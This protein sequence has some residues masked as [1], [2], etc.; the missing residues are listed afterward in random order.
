MSWELRSTVLVVVLAAVG[1]LA[2]WPRA[3]DPTP[4]GAPTGPAA[5]AA[6][7]RSPPPMDADLAGLR[8][9]ANLAPCPSPAPGLGPASGL[10]PA[11][12]PSSAPE[13]SSAGTSRPASVP[14]IAVPCLGAPGTVDLGAALAGRAAL[15]NVWASWCGPCREEIPALAGYTTRPGSVPVIGVNV[16]DQPAAALSLLADL[17]AHYPSV[18]D[19]D[20]ALWSALH[21]PSIIPFSYIVYPG[22]AIRPIT[23]PMVF[24]SPDQ[25]S[26]TVAHYLQDTGR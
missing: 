2:L 20:G 23:P 11:P 5:A 10:G 19:S 16:Q 22:G 9:R 18:A 15:L 6:D 4:S 12:Q 25:V 24:H 13:P 8:Q 3:A 26:R 14:G 17:G 1:V 21:V 7:R